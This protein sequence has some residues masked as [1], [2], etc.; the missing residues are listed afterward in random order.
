[1]RGISSGT[2][3]NLHQKK[4]TLWDN[5]SLEHITGIFLV[6]QRKASMCGFHCIFIFSKL[7]RETNDMRSENHVDSSK[8]IRLTTVILKAW[9]FGSENKKKGAVIIVIIEH[10]IMSWIK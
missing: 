9:R 5:L 3:N 2:V 4:I 7:F 8:I 10:Q 1:M 6:I